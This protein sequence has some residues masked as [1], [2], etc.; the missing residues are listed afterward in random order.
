MN[1]PYNGKFRVSQE[2]KGAAHDGLDLVGVD[3]KEI[4]STINGVVE[5]AGWENA[6]NHKQGFGLYVRI[7]K[8]GTNE[9]YYFGHLSKVN[10]K[11]GQS[12][13]I[14][15]V[16]GV[17]GST[18]KSTGSHCHYCCRNNGS[19]SE[20]LDIC[21][22]SGIPN[23]IGTYDDGYA[24]KLAQKAVQAPVTVKP[25][26][27]TPS[28]KTNEQVAREVLQGKWGNGE[29]RKKRLTAA[30]YNYSEVQAK[31]NELLKAPQP[32][33]TAPAEIIYTVKKGDTLS[34]IAKK[35]G[36]TYQK[37]AANN[38]IKDPNKIYVGQKLKI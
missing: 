24:A 7:K 23:K 20:I 35:Y 18:G 32:K 8:D 10:V 22:I 15:Q 38:N 13:K 30:G 4:H 21:K 25:V 1:A 26:V 19:K 6:L 31:V 14:G 27:S 28:M 34:A 17:E 33:N 3:S 36:T 11:A 37:I 5:K 2:F 9:K 16:I 12:V 29:E